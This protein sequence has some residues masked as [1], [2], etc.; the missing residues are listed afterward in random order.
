MDPLGDTGWQRLKPQRAG[1]ESFVVTP[2]MRLARTHAV[3]VAGDTLVALALAGSLF[4]SIS[5]TQARDRVALYLALTMAPFALVAPLI[6]PWLDRIQGGRRWV[7]VGANALRA[8]LAVLMISHIDSLLLFPEAF[9]MLV[10]SKSYQVAKSALVPTVVASDDELVEANSKLS[11][12]SGIMGFAAAIP[13]GLAVLVADSQGALFLAVGAF[14]GAALL[15]S[16][17]PATRVAAAPAS[18]L[19]RDELRSAGIRLAAS[20]MALLRGI[21]G[22]LTF[23]LA[24]EFRGKDETWMLGLAIAASA[25]GSLL[26][27]LAAPALRRADLPEE[28][29][30]Q[31]FLGI[32]AAAGL[33]TA[34]VG[35]IVGAALL[36]A[37]VGLAASAGKLAFDSVV[38]RDAPDANRGR[39]FA[40]FETRFQLVWVAGAFIPV[41]VHIP[42]R[43]GFLAIAAGATFALVSYMAGSRAVASGQPVPRRTIDTKKLLQRPLE[44]RST[45]RARRRERAAAEAVPAALAMT[46]DRPEGADGPDDLGAGARADATS[47]TETSGGLPALPPPPPPPPPYV[48]EPENGQGHARGNGAPAR[49][50]DDTT[51]VIDPTQLF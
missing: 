5:P 30:V 17:I 50:D 10:L 49:N 8:I 51:I 25:I 34:Y 31:L 33:I 15:A 9:S 45:R 24:F 23:L 27:A 11:L 7:L 28:R 2:F 40:R 3:S 43:I 16:Q 18:T 6:G 35:G 37:T 42:A 4:F 47:V 19:E 38:Q 29:I 14:I 39:S 20:A 22:F 46:S 1:A 41:L 21:V 48:P 32:T 36:A 13:G 12:L 26:G 44:A